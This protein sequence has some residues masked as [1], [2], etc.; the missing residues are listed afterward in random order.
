M[1]PTLPTKILIALDFGPLTDPVLVWSAELARRLDASLVLLHV[2]ALPLVG[3]GPLAPVPEYYPS[4]EDIEAVHGQLRALAVGHGIDAPAIVVV[5][6]H[7]GDAI[8]TNA[9]SQKANLIVMGTHGRG[10]IARTFLGSAA[11]HV[12]RHAACPVVTMRSA[13]GSSLQSGA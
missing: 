4:P 3:G 5:A 7:I 9:I 10:A 1:T 8:V 2:L 6:T 13:P 12:V 11:E